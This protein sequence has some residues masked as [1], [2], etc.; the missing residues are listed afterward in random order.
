M[1]QIPDRE[2]ETP[3]GPRPGRRPRGPGTAVPRTSDRLPCAGRPPGGGD[4]DLAPAAE[5]AIT[6]RGTRAQLEHGR[7]DCGCSRLLDGTRLPP[8]RRRRLRGLGGTDGSLS[9]PASRVPLPLRG[10]CGW[11]RGSS[12]GASPGGTPSAPDLA[13][14]AR[15]GLRTPL[16]A[17]GTPKATDR[18]AAG[19]GEGEVDPLPVVEVMARRGSGVLRRGSGSEAQPRARSAAASQASTGPRVR[20]ALPAPASWPAAGARRSRACRSRGSAPSSRAAA[21]CRQHRAS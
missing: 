11:S 21:I 4:L 3:S 2:S 17:G 15:S 20:T 10:R 14:R 6:V 12:P 19:N 16:G 1:Y 5:A 8:A 7:A 18:P 13:L 9:A